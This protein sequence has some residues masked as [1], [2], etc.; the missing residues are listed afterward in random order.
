MPD[1]LADAWHA[2]QD[3]G[4]PDWMIEREIFGQSHMEVGAYL[5]GLWGLPN[6][7]IEAVAYHH[8]PSVYA[9]TEFSPLTAVHAALV[10]VTASGPDEKV[11]VDA[12]HIEKLNLT[13]QM[14]EWEALYL[15]TAGDSEGLTDE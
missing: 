6:P 10:I 8:T 2:A 3:S 7:I 1:E 14:P 4:K 12:E 13:A 11:A 9:S 15:E 5:V